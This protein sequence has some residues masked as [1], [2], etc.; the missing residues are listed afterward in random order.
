MWTAVLSGLFSG[1]IGALLGVYTSNKADKRQGDLLK[2][3]AEKDLILKNQIEWYNDLRHAIA[4]LIECFIQTNNVL[5]KLSRE[6]ML[7]KGLGD[8]KEATEYSLKEAAHIYQEIQETRKQFETV[9]SKTQGQ[10]VLVRLYLFNLKPDEI[11]VLNEIRRLITSYFNNKE[12]IPLE[13]MDD[14]INKVRILLKKQEE[15]IHEK[16]S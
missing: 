3:Q 16:I 13:E 8:P 5:D 1:I 10:I 15:K 9:F 2:M 14:L 7:A 11:E 12:K 4:S 6:E